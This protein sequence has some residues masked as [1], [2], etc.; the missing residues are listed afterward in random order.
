SSTGRGKTADPCTVPDGESAVECCRSRGR[1]GAVDTHATRVQAHAR[2]HAA[3]RAE[4]S[5]ELGSVAVSCRAN[6]GDG[7]GVWYGSCSAS[8]MDW[9]ASRIAKRWTKADRQSRTESDAKRAAGRRGCVVDCTVDWRG[10]DD[11]HD[12]CVAPCAAGF[13]DGSPSADEP[14]GAKRSLQKSRRGSNRMA[15]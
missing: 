11:A 9:N 14:D 10:T 1:T 6:P 3:T 2:K 13:Q 7:V 5:D 4:H 8:C 12:A 15:A